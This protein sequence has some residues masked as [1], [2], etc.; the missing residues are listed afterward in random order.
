MNY[1]NN[2][3]FIGEKEISESHVPLVNGD[4]LVLMSDGVTN[5]GI[6][7]LAANGWKRDDLISLLERLDTVQMSA[8]HIA[9]Q[10]VSCCLSLSQDSLDDDTT[11]LVIKLRDRSVVNMLVG[12]PE[13]REDD[14]KVLKLF[15]AKR[16]TGC[17]RRQH[18]P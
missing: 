16:D 8:A 15:F 6:G 10:I 1:H 13:N 2:I 12:P 11:A 18:G 9:A 17:L 3:H 7:K 5:A 14:N 4:I